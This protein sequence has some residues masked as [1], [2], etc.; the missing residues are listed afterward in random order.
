[1]GFFL[2]T[3]PL[4]LDF[5]GGEGTAVSF[6]LCASQCF[7]FSLCVTF[8]LTLAWPFIVLFFFCS[9]AGSD[10]LCCGMFLSTVSS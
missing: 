8:P 9:P 4:D 1:V 7:T 10:F 2:G 3:S 5:L 6:F